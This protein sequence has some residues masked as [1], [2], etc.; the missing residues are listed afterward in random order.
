LEIIEAMDQ[1]CIFCKII[2]REIPSSIVFENEQ[3]MAIMDIRPINE[4]HVLVMP[5][6]CYQF[7]HQLP[8]EINQELFR[9]VTEIEKS[10]WQ[11]EGIR[12]E[13]TNILQNNGRIAGQ[14]VNHVH[15]HVIP[16]FTGDDFKFKYQ[17]KRPSREALN[18]L[19]ENIKLQMQG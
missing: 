5:K 12:C 7:L 4:G 18:Q 17:A 11:T 8:A 3:V 16:R 9:I 2:N 10:L 6:A 1:N 19:S 14:E 13:G 15:F